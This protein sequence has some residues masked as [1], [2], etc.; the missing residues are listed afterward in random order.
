MGVWASMGFNGGPSNC[1]AK[2][3]PGRSGP[4]T[5]SMGFNGGPSNCPAK[6]A[7]QVEEP[8]RVDAASMEGRAIARPNRRTRRGCAD[9]E[10][11]FNGGPSNCPAKRA[12]RARR[13]SRSCAS[14]EGRAIARPNL[15]LTAVVQE[16]IDSLQWRAEQLP[17]QTARP[18]ARTHPRGRCFNG[19]P[20]N[21]PAK[22]EEAG[23]LR[24]SGRAS[25]E[26]RAIARPNQVAEV[27]G[28][29]LAGA[30][31]EG[32]AIA[33][34]N[35]SKVAPCFAMRLLQW[36]AEQLPGQT[37]AASV[38]AIPDLWLQWR[39]EQL[40]GQTL[41]T[42]TAANESNWLQWRAEQLPGQTTPSWR[43]SRPAVLLQWRAEQLPGQTTIS[44]RRGRLKNPLQWR[45]EQ[46]P[47]QTGP[48]PRHHL[49]R[50]L[51]FNG[52]PSNCP[53]KLSEHVTRT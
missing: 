32:R 20:S 52:G 40:P 14:M 26:G 17:G 38:F 11:R 39:A 19:G 9:G 53:A 41:S 3:S 30:S 4:P 7:E 31:M 44:K 18:R 50:P 15:Y 22:P 16:K 27:V 51:G 21:C 45:A 37:Q 2:R 49:R 24:R 1:P 12:C 36:R 13:G 28:V 43:P 5:S 25:M 10:S 8:E 46:L 48:H 23:H 34:P 35:Q 29:R 6:R 47:G 42:P 33:R